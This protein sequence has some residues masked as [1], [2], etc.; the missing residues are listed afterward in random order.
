MV[1]HDGRGWETVSALD[2]TRVLLH[3]LWNMIDLKQ[4]QKDILANKVAKGF[5]MTDMNEEFIHAFEELAEASAAY[6]KKLP[7]FGEEL[8]DVMIYL[9]GIAEILK[10]DLEQ[11]LVKKIEKNR[12]REYVK[13]DGVPVRTKD[14]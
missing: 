2:A 9:L 7:D 1:H 13:I 6:R 11:E 10:I 3:A 4:L 14:A 8:A 5:N 12:K